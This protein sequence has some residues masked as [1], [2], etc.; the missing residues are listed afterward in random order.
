MNTKRKTL[1]NKL[2]KLFSEK[3]RRVG[4]CERCG[5]ETNLQCC[6]IYSRKNKWLRWEFENALCLDAGCHM[7]WWHLEPAEAIRWA[8]T[9]RDFDKLDELKRINRPMKEFDMLEIYEKLKS[10]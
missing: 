3:V 5:K 9:V 4:H 2:D 1:S 7:F 8:M 6:H 10:S